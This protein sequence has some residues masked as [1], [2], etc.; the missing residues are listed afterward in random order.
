MKPSLTFYQS[1]VVFLTEL[2]ESVEENARQAFL[3][4]LFALLGFRMGAEVRIL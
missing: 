3:A 2:I 4:S 1:V